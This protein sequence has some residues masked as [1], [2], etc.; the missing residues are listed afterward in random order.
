[1]YVVNFVLYLMISRACN[2]SRSQ[3]TAWSTAEC[4]LIC[5]LSLMSNSGVHLLAHSIQP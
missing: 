2:S 3:A 5:F 4:V 1:M